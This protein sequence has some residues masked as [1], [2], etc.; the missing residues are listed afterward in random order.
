MVKKDVLQFR[1]DPIPGYAALILIVVAFTFIL[2]NYRTAGMGMWS[3]VMEVDGKYYEASKGGG[4]G[5]ENRWHREMDPDV[6]RAFLFRDRLLGY[7]GLAA[8]VV[9]P[10]WTVISLC[11]SIRRANEKARQQK[12]PPLPGEEVGERRIPP[13]PDADGS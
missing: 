3:I 2:F 4:K 6:A 11:R 13:L 1:L 7:G 10:T 9:L 5:L 12:I 8:L